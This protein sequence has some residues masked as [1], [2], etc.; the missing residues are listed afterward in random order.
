MQVGNDENYDK[1]DT[2]QNNSSTAMH[3]QS[4]AQR[5]KKITLRG[6]MSTSRK[7]SIRV[8]PLTKAVVT[9][10]NFGGKYIVLRSKVICINKIMQFFICSLHCRACIHIFSSYKIFLLFLLCDLSYA[11]NAVLKLELIWYSI[12]NRLYD[13]RENIAQFAA[14]LLKQCLLLNDGVYVS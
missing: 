5:L 10:E 11:V 1:C 9:A 12:F 14:E 2:L 8:I 4:H 7:R 3:K 13:W 6:K